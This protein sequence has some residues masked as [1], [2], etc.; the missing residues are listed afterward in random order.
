MDIKNLSRE[1][2]INLILSLSEIQYDVWRYH[3][4]NPEKIDIVEQY[5]AV[6]EEIEKIKKKLESLEN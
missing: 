1:E 5:N 3:P 6:S 4:N 2:L